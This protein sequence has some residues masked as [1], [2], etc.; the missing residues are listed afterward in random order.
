ME[1]SKGFT[2]IEPLQI[3][4]LGLDVLINNAGM[5]YK[6]ASTA[7]FIEQATNTLKTN[8]TGTLNITRALLPLVRPGGRIVMVSST[9]GRLSIVKPHLQ[10]Q[11]SSTSLTEQQLV[12]LMDQ[13]VQDVASGDHTAKGWPTTAYGVS[14]VGMTAFTK[15]IARE[16]SQTDILVNACCPGWVRSDMAGQNA[17]RSPDEGAETP[18]Y[19]AMLPANS[20][21]GEFWRDKQVVSW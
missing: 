3:L 6:M 1:V 2:S 4:L 19:L 14:K 15:I 16:L 18:V 9:A 17:P 5:A 13:F 8:F 11:F 12:S 7:P 10:E 20:P 21:S